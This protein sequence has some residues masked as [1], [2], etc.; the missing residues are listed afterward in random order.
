[1]FCPEENYN[2]VVK[3]LATES[4]SAELR[5]EIEETSMMI[6]PLVEGVLEKCY[7]ILSQIELVE[8]SK[9]SR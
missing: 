3:T 9:A 1:M 4:T 8:H 6:K 2:T 7:V 5:V